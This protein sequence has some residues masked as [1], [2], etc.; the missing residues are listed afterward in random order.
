[1][2]TTEAVSTKTENKAPVKTN[3]NTAAADDEYGQEYVIDRPSFK[4]ENQTERDSQNPKIEVYKGDAVVGYW[5]AHRHLGKT[6]DEQTGRERDMFAYFV[7]LTQKCTVFDREDNK[8]EA[9]PGDEIMVWETSQLLQAIPP[10]IANHPT[11]VLNMKM[12]PQ[13]RVPH[14]NDKQKRMWRMKFY[15]SAKAPVVARTVIGGGGN[16]VAGLLASLPKVVQQLPDGS[17]VMVGDG[18]IP[19]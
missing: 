19:F 2:A 10:A 11:K 12:A 18:P 14:P 13:A 9:Q 4:P 17:Q 3:G 16:A 1:M 5:F 15:P 7:K 6:K 8:I